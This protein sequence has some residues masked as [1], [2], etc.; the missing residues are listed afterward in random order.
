[1][2]AVKCTAQRTPNH[3]TYPQDEYP[4]RM[5]L[6]PSLLLSYCLSFGSPGG[7]TYNE[8]K[9][10]VIMLADEGEAGG[11]ALKKG[12]YITSVSP[13]GDWRVI[14]WETG[15]RCGAQAAKSFPPGQRGSWA[16]THSATYLG[17]A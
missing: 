2:H 3:W 5:P 6:C 8:D 16:L 11:E 1:M 12:C 17:T 10:P 7:R 9:V 14:R 15:S 13:V 4:S